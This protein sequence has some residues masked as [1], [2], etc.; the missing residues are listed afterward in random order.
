M[1]R[2][3]TIEVWNPDDDDEV[4]TVETEGTSFE[5][6]TDDEGEYIGRTMTGD[7]VSFDFHFPTADVDSETV[8]N[9]LLENSSFEYG[10]AVM[11]GQTIVYDMENDSAFDIGCESESQ[12]VVHTKQN[13]TRLTVQKVY[14]EV[15]STL[16]VP[17]RVVKTQTYHN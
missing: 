17:V 12:I 3:E 11:D 6:I 10:D 16:E 7:S 2:R 15:V 4:F 9:E 5:Q 1:N 8:L 13:T 14:E